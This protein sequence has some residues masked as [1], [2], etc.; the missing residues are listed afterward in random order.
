VKKEDKSNASP[1]IYILSKTKA[2]VQKFKVA[3]F[4]LNEVILVLLLSDET[5]KPVISS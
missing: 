3:K 1:K 4:M 2:L 5:F